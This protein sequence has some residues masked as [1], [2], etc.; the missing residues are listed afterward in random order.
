M[1]N[2]YNKILFNNFKEFF[3]RRN[4]IKNIYS[5]LNDTFKRKYKDFVYSTN[6]K[7]YFKDKIWEYL[8]EPFISPYF[9]YDYELRKIF[10]VYE[11]NKNSIEIQV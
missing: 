2:F 3:E 10:E 5:I 11:K 8:N 1:Q 4:I 9:V 7:D 6:L